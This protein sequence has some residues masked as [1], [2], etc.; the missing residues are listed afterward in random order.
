LSG[1]APS[2]HQPAATSRQSL[3]PCVSSWAFS[4]PPNGKKPY[5]REDHFKGGRPSGSNLINGLDGND[6]L[7]GGRG[8][9]T[10]VF[11]TKLSKK[12]IDRVLVP[13]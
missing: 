3:Q 11:N 4:R 9:E 10:F 6:K 2:A 13:V 7:K 5:I 12:N 1:L 8:R